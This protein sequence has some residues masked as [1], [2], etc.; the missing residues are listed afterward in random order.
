MGPKSQKM[1]GEGFI[2][3][4][5]ADIGEGK[6]VWWTHESRQKEVEFKLVWF[7][8]LQRNGAAPNHP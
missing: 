8:P 2:C 4:Q 5:F 7:L 1:I 3:N 6:T